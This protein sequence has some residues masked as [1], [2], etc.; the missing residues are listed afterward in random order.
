M[1]VCPTV[2]ELHFYGC[3]HPCY[4]MTGAIFVLDCKEESEDGY[5]IYRVG[6]I[7]PDFFLF[8]NK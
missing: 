4:V 1:S 8:L 2:L 5:S 6:Q 7:N 3:C